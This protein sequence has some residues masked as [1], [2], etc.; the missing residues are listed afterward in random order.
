V[1][2]ELHR[3]V[4]SGP[5]LSFDLQLV[6]GFVDLPPRFSGPPRVTA[7]ICRLDLAGPAGSLARVEASGDLQQ[8]SEA[9]Q[10]VLTNGI[11]QFQEST[12]ASGLAR[13]Y[14]LKY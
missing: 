1:A 14:R 8:W 3:L 5:D 4:P 2:V 10:V 13:F 7:G 12:G 9:N 6:E 11:G